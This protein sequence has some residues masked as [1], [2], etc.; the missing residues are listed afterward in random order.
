MLKIKF[1]VTFAA[2]M[3]LISG[4]TRVSAQSTQ[5]GLSLGPSAR[6]FG[7]DNTERFHDDDLYDCEWDTGFRFD[8]P[9]D[10]ASG[11]YCAELCQ[12]KHSDSV[13]FVVRPPRGTA[14]AALALIL[15]T[16]SYWAYGNHHM[17][18]EWREEERITGSFSVIGPTELYLH[19]HPELGC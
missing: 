8:I 11:L 18:T 5:E 15:P 9:D 6:P 12:G 2:V 13:P 4:S 17:P 10:L 7:S 19:E 14:R 1:L 3:L 16:A